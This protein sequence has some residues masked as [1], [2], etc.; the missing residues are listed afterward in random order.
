MNITGHNDG[1]YKGNKMAPTITWLSLEWQTIDGSCRKFWRGILQTFE[2]SF[3]FG[4]TRHF[5][6]RAV[7]VAVFNDTFTGLYERKWNTHSL[8]QSYPSIESVTYI[9]RTWLTF[10]RQRSFGWF[11]W[12]V[13]SFMTA[14]VFRLQMTFDEPSTSFI[15]VHL[16]YYGSVGFIIVRSGLFLFVRVY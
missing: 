12:Q 6:S 14:F 3:L 5:V 16:V 15:L 2:S 10:S 7:H 11:D 1:R 4:S 13:R 9:S 8:C